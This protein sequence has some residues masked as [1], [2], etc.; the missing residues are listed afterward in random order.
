MYC[1]FRVISQRYLSVQNE[2]I[3]EFRPGSQERSDVL[4]S[5]V[6]VQSKTQ[7]I[8]LVI[9]NEEIW[10]DDIKYQVCVRDL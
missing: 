4:K 10:T 2:P 7:E 1:I 5:L 6:D 9:G 3:L 8:P